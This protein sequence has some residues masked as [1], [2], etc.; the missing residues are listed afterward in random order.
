MKFTTTAG[1]LAEALAATAKVTPKNPTMAVFAGVRIAATPASVSITGADDGADTTVTITLEATDVTAGHVVLPPKPISA[2][3]ATL[4]A[5]TLVTVWA[6]KSTEVRVE[7]AG[8]SPYTFRAMD[9]TFPSAG[10]L[11]DDPRPVDLAGLNTAVAAVK[12]IAKKTAVVQLVS[13][14]GGARLYATDGVRLVRARLPGA[15]FGDFSGL[16]SYQVCEQLCDFAVDSVQ[17]DKSG[18]LFA[19]SGPRASVVTRLI[20]SQFPAVDSVLDVFPTSTVAVPAAALKAALHRLSA[21]TESTRPVVVTIHGDQLVLQV[22][23]A[24]IGSGAERI[25]LEVPSAVE[26][27]FGVNLDFF[28]AATGSVPGPYVV[29][30]W[31]SPVQPIFVRSQDGPGLAVT[32]VIMPVRL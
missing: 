10:T 31:S 28:A 32:H 22:D 30:G 21:V 8:S 25:E 12:D 11:A 17:V 29:L 4:R 19:A 16:L 1:S 5:A 7:A 9:A 14:A 26:V 13:D 15:G 27:A 3:L 2:Y 24:N 23:S 20:D 6:E 18:R